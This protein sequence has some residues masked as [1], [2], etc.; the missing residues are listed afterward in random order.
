M[1][2]ILKMCLYLYRRI[3]GN[4]SKKYV[5]KNGFI[6]HKNGE[7]IVSIKAFRRNCL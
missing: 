4:F 5:Y 1:N 6:W 3:Y 2:N 7:R